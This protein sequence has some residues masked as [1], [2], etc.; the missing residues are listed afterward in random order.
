MSE[1]GNGKKPDSAAGFGKIAIGVRIGNN[2]DP[3]WVKCWTHYI[4]SGLCH[5]DVILAPAIELPHHWT[6]STI[7]N[8]FLTKTDCDSLLMIDSDMVF[9]PN[10]AR[11]LRFNPENWPYG[12]VQAMCVSRKPPHAPIILAESDGGYQALMPDMDD[13]TIPVG[14]VG[15]AFTLIRRSTFVAV[16]ALMQPD[17]LYFNWG[18]NGLG[19]DQSF[20]IKARAAGIQIGVDTELAIGHRMAIEVWHDKE[21]GQP[22]FRGHANSSFMELLKRDEKIE[23]KKEAITHG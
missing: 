15:L 22:A 10:D 8:Q 20:C 23:E 13:K 9:G 18:I 16:K 11:K 1:Q 3:L 17:E 7:A 5:K 4:M 6:A 14:M 21:S 12:I 2:A 19:E